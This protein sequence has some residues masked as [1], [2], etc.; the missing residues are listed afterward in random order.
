MFIKE[1]RKKVNLTEKVLFFGNN[2]SIVTKKS[3][4][5]QIQSNKN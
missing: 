4:G 5:G 1:D 2:T 3:C